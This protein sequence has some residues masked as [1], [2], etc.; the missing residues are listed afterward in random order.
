[1][2]E[3]I[4]IE[5]QSARS[6]HLSK[7]DHDRATDTLNKA[8][9]M[10]FALWKGVGRATSE[11]IAEFYEVPLDTIQSTIRLHKKELVSDGLETMKGK[12]LKDVLSSFDKTSKA[13]SLTVWTPRAALRAAFFLTQSEVAKQIRTLVLDIVEQ[14]PQQSQTDRELELEKLRAQRIKDEKEL[15]AMKHGLYQSDRIM[16]R[17][18]C[19]GEPLGNLLAP[20]TEPVKPETRTPQSEDGI[21]MTDFM[22][23]LDCFDRTPSGKFKN[24]DRKM[25]KGLLKDLGIDLDKGEGTAKLEYVQPVRGI[26]RDRVSEVATSIREEVQKQRPNIYTHAISSSALRRV[27]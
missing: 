9:A 5:S 16:Y 24:A 3:S 6:G 10:V 27:K 25:V 8:K 13:P 14:A 18:V 12:R 7:L 22:R 4:L 1:M 19:D 17:A 23:I 11:Q 21:S 26:P 15:I 20:A 2:D